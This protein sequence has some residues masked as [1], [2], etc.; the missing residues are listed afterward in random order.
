GRKSLARNMDNFVL[1]F[2]MFTWEMGP[3]D[4]RYYLTISPN[5]NEELLEVSEEL[6]ASA[7][8][9]KRWNFYAAK[10]KKEWDLKFKVFD[11]FMT[12]HEVDA[13]DWQYVWEHGPSRKITITVMA[14]SI[15]H[16]DDETKLSAAD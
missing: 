15:H 10:P 3:V 16:L 11:D 5:G 2:G 12:P 13:S 6:I 8:E 1:H 4:G 7:P 14:N 9:L